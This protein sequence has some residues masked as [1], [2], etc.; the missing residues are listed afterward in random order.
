MHRSPLEHQMQPTESRI[1][2]IRK[3]PIRSSNKPQIFFCTISLISK[4]KNSYASLWLPLHPFPTHSPATTTIDHKAAHSEQF[5]I[6]TVLFR[7][8]P[9]FTS[10]CAEN[11]VRPATG[12]AH[13]ESSGSM[14]SSLFGLYFRCIFGIFWS[15]LCSAA[16]RQI[17]ERESSPQASV[18]LLGFFYKGLSGL[19]SKWPSIW[20]LWSVVLEPFRIHSD[21]FAHFRC[22]MAVFRALQLSASSLHGARTLQM[23]LH[24]RRLASEWSG[25]RWLTTCGRCSRYIRTL[26]NSPQLY[27]TSAQLYNTSA[28]L[29]NTSAPLYNTHSISPTVWPVAAQQ[30][31]ASAG[32]HVRAD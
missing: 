8:S 22:A 21:T 20:E 24:S 31:T 9:V 15:W 7:C 16:L 3:Q 6:G 32:L 10:V 25:S 12:G 2:P 17:R 4:R 19:T 28:P 1:L 23:Q 14:C 5:R 30:R 27:N 29:Y 18:A 13:W 11:L 26:Y